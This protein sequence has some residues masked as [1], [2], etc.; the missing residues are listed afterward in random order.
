[1]IRPLANAAIGLLFVALIGSVWVQ[2]WAVPSFVEQTVASFPEVGL[3]AVPSIVWAFVAT[4]SWQVA[5]VLG[6][7]L[8]ILVRTERFGANSYGYVRAV[9]ACLTVY[10]GLVLA[11]W[12]ALSVLEWATP[13]VIFIL[14]LSA[15][16]AGAAIALLLR[17]LQA[18]GAQRQ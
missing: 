12:I 16:A 13:G 10:V 5:A 18:N 11:A 15:V 3:I 7:R 14:F 2:L 6:I 17:F 4:L 8:L 1:M 9:I